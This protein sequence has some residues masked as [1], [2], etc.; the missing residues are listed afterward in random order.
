[1]PGQRTCILPSTSLM[2]IK[3]K[4]RTDFK[5][6]TE[7]NMYGKVLLILT[8]T[9]AMTSAQIPTL[10]W[11]PEYVPMAN[12][13]MNR[14]LG[15]WYEAERYF[16]LAEVVSRCVMSNYTKGPDGKLRVSNEV[17]SRITGIKRILEGEIKQ[18]ASK[19]EEGKLHVKYTALPL[20]PETHYSVLETDYDNYAVLWS[21]SGIGPINAQNAWV[22][23]RDRIAPGSILQKAYGVLD[24]YKISKAFFVKTNQDDCVYQAASTVT[25]QDSTAVNAEKEESE[26]TDEHARNVSLLS[27]DSA[28][29]PVRHVEE[30]IVEEKI[31]QRV[32]TVPQRILKVAEFAKKDDKLVEK[33]TKGL[34]DLEKKSNLKKF[35]DKL[36]KKEEILEIP[37]ESSMLSLSI[38]LVLVGMASAQIPALGSCPDVQILTDFDLGKYLGVWYEIEKYFSVFELGGKCVEANYTLRDNTTVNVINRQISSITGVAMSIEGYARFEGPPNESKLLVTFPSVP[39]AG[40]APYWVLGTDYKNYAVVWSCRNYGIFNAK[41]VWILARERSPSVVVMQDAYQVLD[42]NRISRA[43]FIRTDQRN[44]TVTY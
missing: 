5:A 23:T 25:I 29:K 14:F 37:K 38:I 21:C 30:S 26:T 24:K 18:A 34:E 10:G 15:T 43:Y 32:E 8:T 39:F 31:P 9:L 17:T 27:E 19:A 28:T 22:M 16:Q 35:D 3:K 13:D 44:C 36:K 33:P 4:H 20:T 1:M 2:Y 42:R 7:N 11:C 41:I 40:D 12:F 6:D